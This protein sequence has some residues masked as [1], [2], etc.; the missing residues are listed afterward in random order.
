MGKYL[1]EFCNTEEELM[2]GDMTSVGEIMKKLQT[3]LKDMPTYFGVAEKGKVGGKQRRR[4]TKRASTSAQTSGKK[5][6]P[7]V[8]MK[9]GTKQQI[10]I[11]NFTGDFTITKDITNNEK[12]RVFLRIEKE[13][14]P[15]TKSTEKD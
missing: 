3:F 2:K 9:M 13:Y 6:L 10:K 15:V 8:V 4:I 1:M 14:C 11:N 7:T 5:K 12:D